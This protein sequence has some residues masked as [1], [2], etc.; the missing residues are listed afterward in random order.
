MIASC[1]LHGGGVTLSHKTSGLLTRCG[2][3]VWPL[4][5]PLPLP[6]RCATSGQS[7]LHCHHTRCL[8]A[9]SAPH[10]AA[11]RS[12]NLAVRRSNG[13]TCYLTAL[14]WHHIWSLDAPLALW[15]HVQPPVAL[16]APPLASRR[17]IGITSGILSLRRRYLYLASLCSVGIT[18]GLSALQLLTALLWRHMWP[19][20][21]VLASPRVRR[22]CAGVTSPLRRIKVVWGLSAFCLH[23][24]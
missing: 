15:N 21:A 8:V 1:L 10:L 3:F 9:P 12:T 14:C 23:H 13:I 7:M 16:L 5:A 20:F 2:H 4:G 22:R 24:I 19:L 17:F 6:L 18:Y 11:Q